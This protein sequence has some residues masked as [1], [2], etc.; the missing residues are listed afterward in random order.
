[1]QQYGQVLDPD[2][3][4]DKDKVYNIFVEYFENPTLTKLK[5]VAEYS[6]YAV[7]SHALLG[8]EQR[9]IML[10]VY[11]DKF[12]IGHQEKMVNLFWISLQTTTS[13]DEHKILTHTYTPRR[14][15]GVSCAIHL[16]DINNGVYKYSVDGL[17]IHV[18]LPPGK[19]GNDSYT[20][21]NKLVNAIETYNTI[22][23][24]VG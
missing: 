12:N 7:K 22:I 4:F 10:F 16:T 15:P 23:T 18:T 9:Y 8:I 19:S 24:F 5:D 20:A 6:L 1:M 3:D 21:H 17:P 14:L 2:Y 13:E 11:K